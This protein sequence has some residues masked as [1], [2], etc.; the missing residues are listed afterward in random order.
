MLAPPKIPRKLANSLKQYTDLRFEIITEVPCEYFETEEHHLKEPQDSSIKWNS[1]KPGLKWGGSW[2]SA[3]FRGDVKLPETAKGR[4]V[5]IEFRTETEGMFS[6]EG[7]C[8]INGQAKGGFDPNHPFVLIS[9]SGKPGTDLHCAVEAYSLHSF[10]S[11]MPFDKPIVVP[12]KCREFMGMNIVIERTEVSQFVFDLKTLL[13]AYEVLDEHSLRR[14]Q[15]LDCLVEV[16]KVIQAMPKEGTEESWLPGVKKAIE[17]MQPCMKQKNSASAPEMGTIAHSHIDTAWLWPIAETQRKCR[18]TFSTMLNLL[19]Q[20]PEVIFFQSAPQHADYVRK[21]DPEIF[22]RM[23]EKIKSGQWEPNGAMWVEPDC[24]I[25]NGESLVR[26]CLYGIQWTREHYGYTPDTFWQPDVFGYSAALPQILQGCGVK[27]F[28]TTKMAWNDTTRFPFDTFEWTGIDGTSVVAHLNSIPQWMDP[29]EMMKEWKWAQHK[30]GQNGRLLSYGYGDGGGGPRHEDME[31]VRR[32]EDFDGLPKAKNTTVSDYMNSVE[33]G[34]HKLPKYV[35]ELYLELHR[36]TLTSLAAIKKGNRDCEV[37]LR[38]AE[39]AWVLAN[40]YGNAEYPH[41]ELREIWK[42][43]LTMQFHD[44]LPGTSIQRAHEEAVEEFLQLQ[45]EI[46]ALESKAYKALSGGKEEHYYIVNQLNWE[47]DFWRMT[48][49]S[50]EEIEVL[51]KSYNKIDRRLE[52]DYI[53]TDDSEI[54]KQS[55]SQVYEHPNGKRKDVYS[56]QLALPGN[57]VTPLMDVADKEP[58]ELMYQFGFEGDNPD[59]IE[60]DFFRIAFEKDG[61]ISSLVYKTNIRNYEFVAP[62]GRL[63]GFLLG[64]DVPELWDNWDIDEDQEMHMQPMAGL[65]SRK[66]ISNG[67][68]F[69]CIRSQYQV[70]KKS[71]I[72]QDMLLFS[73][74]IY[75]GINHQRVEFHT[76]VDWHEKHQLL[77]TEFDLNMHCTSAKHEIQFGHV[78][79]PTHR[80]QLQD[81]AQFEVS[82]QKWT[83]MG[84]ASRRMCLM[85]DCK[86]GV[87]TKDNKLTLSLIK[88]GTHPDPRGDEGLHDFSY[89]IELMDGKDDVC[90]AVRSAHE[91]NHPPRLVKGDFPKEVLDYTALFQLS[92][93]EIKLGLIVESVKGRENG[94]GFVIR[95]YEPAG[96]SLTE[97]IYFN[98][99]V[100][101]VYKT[102]MLEENGEQL[103][104]EDNTIW[105]DV[106]AFEVVTLI[107]EL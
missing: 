82:Q 106:K 54:T 27:Y 77:K 84:D 2:I 21:E 60:S 57:S 93:P 53:G 71:K 66:V 29:K 14:A 96:G 1:A 59:L 34:A 97:I 55:I 4:R 17:I 56:F 12:D 23:K 50:D 64:E 43:F 73:N 83:M 62:G 103:K 90:S 19:D 81:R 45:K 68:L 58:E 42:R 95:L 32:M 28:L 31:M 92:M 22:E 47:R 85:N 78:E 10:P 76:H 9:E 70:G 91:F 46:R 3:W 80:N 30:D 52:E 107:C 33:N 88:S 11:T 65:I 7:L 94:K 44:I 67:P 74:G 13:D 41:D 100:K 18:R 104:L 89:A 40:V 24:N 87:G 5:W 51:T 48:D 86:Y 63:N 39:F 98:V 15:I 6:T 69:T 102:N 26:Q 8:Y 20:Y 61:S 101:S 37:A 99:P 35:G 38:D 16:F 49:V 72:I 79:R 36:G 75:H 25:P 105:F